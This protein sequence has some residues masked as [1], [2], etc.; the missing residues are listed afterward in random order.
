MLAPP[1]R[2][3]RPHSGPWHPQSPPDSARDRITAWCM[4]RRFDPAERDQARRRPAE[5]RTNPTRPMPSKSVAGDHFPEIAAAEGPP[6]LY[7][8]TVL[9]ESDGAITHAH[10]DTAR[11]IARSGDRGEDTTPPRKRVARIGARQRVGGHE[12]VVVLGRGEL[13]PREEPAPAVA[14][15]GADG[16]DLLS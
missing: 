4:S 10:V 5:A 13:G 15:A 1:P 9:D 2:G 12:V 6:C 3:R 11:V 16:V 14:V 7:V 8:H